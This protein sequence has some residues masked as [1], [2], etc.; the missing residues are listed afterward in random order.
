VLPDIER[1]TRLLDVPMAMFL[2][3]FCILLRPRALADPR[4]RAAIGVGAFNL[5]RASALARTPGFEAL[6]LDVVDDLALG[7]MLKQHG[8]RSAVMNGHDYVGVRWYESVPDMARGAEKATLASFAAFSLMRLVVICVVL[9]ALELAPF[10]GVFVVGRPVL[11]LV[12]AGGVL[13]AMLAQLVPSAAFARPWWPALFTPVATVLSV[14]LMLRAGFLAV[15]RGGMLWR[16]TL[17]PTEMLR[18]GARLR[19]P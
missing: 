16:G 8:A 15:W 6:R 7:Q 2:R 4:S 10:V 18:R 13:C 1:G 3:M 11:Q 12:A 9:L 19:F 14:A 17:Y 5:V